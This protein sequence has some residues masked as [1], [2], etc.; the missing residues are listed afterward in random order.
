M[1]GFYDHIFSC[2]Y[3]TSYYAKTCIATFIPDNYTLL[4]FPTTGRFMYSLEQ[5]KLGEVSFELGVGYC[6]I[7]MRMFMYIYCKQVKNGR[8]DKDLNKHIE[9]LKAIIERLKVSLW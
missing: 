4:L 1:E 3:T 5:I 2:S 8:C 6:S 9:S 7:N